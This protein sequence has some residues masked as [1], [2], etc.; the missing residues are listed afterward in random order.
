ML[1]LVTLKIFT[2]LC[3][4]K[5]KVMAGVRATRKCI[6]LFCHLIKTSSYPLSFGPTQSLST[7]VWWQLIWLPNLALSVF[8][9]GLN[10]PWL[11]DK[12][13]HF[14][15]L[16]LYKAP[17][18]FWVI[19]QLSVFL[20]ELEDFFPYSRWELLISYKQCVILC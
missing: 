12:G 2:V 1:R 8:F 9:L 4:Y 16:Y 17:I 5:L 7:G 6:C 10:F 14:L 18:Y 15:A 13:F 20:A 3:S 11:I 19:F